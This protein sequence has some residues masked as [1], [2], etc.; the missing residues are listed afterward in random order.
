VTGGAGFLG[1]HLCDALLADG[2]S[3][4]AVDNL[5]TGRLSNLAHLSNES[6]FEFRE[7]DVCEPFDCGRLEWVFHLASPASPVDYSEHGIE[8]LQVGSLGT[9]HALDLARKYGARFLQASTSE[10]YGDP[11]EHPQKETYWGHV[12]PIGPRSVYDESKRFAE[13]ATMAYLR[14]YKVDTHIVRIF[15]TYGPR[16][17]INDGR[18]VPNFM[19]QALR[20]EDLTIYGDGS[21]TRSFC[22]VS[23][24]IEGIVRLAKSDE[25]EPVNI[26]NPTEFTILECAQKVLDVTGSKS[27]LRYEPLPVDDPKQRRPDITKAKRLLG[28]EP[29]VD[30]ENGLRMS[31]EYFRGAVGKA[32]VSR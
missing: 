10:C 8:T 27:K 30:L 16:M 20:G 4:V 22:Y 12:N 28:W 9:F 11:L 19:K 7:L 17:Q 21:Q 18:V 29:K 15:N 2:C 6:R 14:Y 3:V 24:E 32:I 26:G 1:S 25:H 23:D 5:L 31:L 13:A